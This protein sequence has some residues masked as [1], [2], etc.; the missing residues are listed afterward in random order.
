[1]NLPLC[2]VCSDTENKLCEILKK[3]VFS[4]KKRHKKEKN[5]T[6]PLDFNEAIVIN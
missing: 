6:K 1:M 2:I 3:A 5:I 4:S